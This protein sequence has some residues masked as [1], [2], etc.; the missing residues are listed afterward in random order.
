MVLIT[1]VIQHLADYTFILYF[2]A[3]LLQTPFTKFY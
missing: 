3:N 2:A 1:F